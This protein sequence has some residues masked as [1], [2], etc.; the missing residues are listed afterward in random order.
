[1]LVVIGANGQLGTELVKAAEERGLACRGLTHEEFDVTANP[2]F[3][4]GGFVYH[5]N[6]DGLTVINTS[7]YHDL[8]KC[9]DSPWSALEI[10]TLA[11]AN[12]ANW[13]NY[14]GA[15]YVYI[16][17]DYC[18]AEPVDANGHPRSVYAKT[19]LAGELATMAVC[20]SALVVRVATLYGAAGCRAKGGGNFID[21]VVAKIR[22]Q[23]PFTLP[24][25]TSVL[26]TYAKYAAGRILLNMDKKGVW[27]A[28]DAYTGLSHYEIGCN[29]ASYLRL[30][31]LIQRIDYDPNDTLRPHRTSVSCR[32]GSQQAHVLQPST[33]T[34]PPLHAYL[35]EKGYL[36][37]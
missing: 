11:S 30:P 24:G 36:P 26:T 33:S 21:T 16:S 12:I 31:N 3:L 1:M 22:E 29:V 6:D 27:Y 7:A 8:T 4:L 14:Y 28:T 17:T 32:V 2:E 35:K 9:E 19:K 37:E 20:P 23:K 10:N 18:E 15:K 5:A 25:Y 34:L 13:C